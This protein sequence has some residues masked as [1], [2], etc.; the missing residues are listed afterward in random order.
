MAA[1]A[2]IV[3]TSTTQISESR[4]ISRDLSWLKFNDRVLDQAKHQDRSIFE[5]LK[6]LTITQSNLD[7]FFMIRV[8]SLYN[9]IDFGKERVDYS[10]LREIPFGARLL[11]EIHFHCE[12]Q[13]RH[14]TEELRPLFK[15]NGFDIRAYEDLV[16]SQ[17]KELKGYF[18]DTIYPML[19]PMLYD[20]YHPFP[21]LTNMRLTFGVVTKK[22]KESKKLRKLSFVQVP[23]NFPRFYE[24]KYRDEFIF[25]PI[26]DIIKNNIDRFF[27]NV[28]I[29]SVN[30][31][32]I[33]RNGD[34]TVEESEDIETN[35]LEELRSKLKTR[36]IRFNK[37]C[38]IGKCRTV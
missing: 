1:L 26:E 18:D 31:F 33:T 27:R 24:L 11:E 36:N 2:E 4:L 19:T 5:R 17:Q 8:G 16:P 30:L 21:L 20:A 28:K 13:H 34:F 37:Y 14:F 3:D 22:P 7:E 10:G 6:F 15:K 32:R 9:Y 38:V 25:V 29:L 35:F 23:S 12:D